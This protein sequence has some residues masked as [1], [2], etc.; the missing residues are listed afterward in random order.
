MIRTLALAAGL[1]GAGVTSQ[2]PEF[3][4]Q[5]LQRLGGQVDALGMVV[6]DFDAS[7]L[8]SGLTR[9]QALEEMTGTAFLSDRQADLRRT[10]RR[11]AVLSDDLATLRAAGPVARIAMPLRVS[12][13]AT[14]A[15]TW[16]DFQP[17]M[18]LT[19]AGILSGSVGFVLGWGALRALWAILRRA[20]AARVQP[21][22][23]PIRSPHRGEPVVAAAI[24]ANPSPVPRLAG[25]RRHP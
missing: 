23:R 24:T 22:H 18:P 16:A 3:T 7:A 10:F 11:H 19:V 12:D 5:Y 15:A 13:P 25:V 4:Q 6:D 8:R 9:N 20:I 17:A 21:R 1:A 14:F 2:Y